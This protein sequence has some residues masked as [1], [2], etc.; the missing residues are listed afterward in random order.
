MHVA[1][2]SRSCVLFGGDDASATWPI[3]SLCAQKIPIWMHIRTFPCTHTLTQ[4]YLN[5]QYIRFILSSN[6]YDNIIAAMHTINVSVSA[7]ACVC[8]LYT[9]IS[10]LQIISPV[11]SCS[12]KRTT[13]CR[14]LWTKPNDWAKWCYHHIL[15][16]FVLKL[17]SWET[18]WLAHTRASERMRPIFFFSCSTSIWFAL[19]EHHSICKNTCILLHSESAPSNDYYPNVFLRFVLFCC[20]ISNN[21]LQLCVV[22][23]SSLFRLI[24]VDLSI[25]SDESLSAW[26][27]RRSIWSLDACWFVEIDQPFGCFDQLQVDW[28]S[29]NEKKNC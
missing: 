5:I 18:V 1:A 13:S 9:H 29:N 10:S 2:L 16:S 23:V 19:W 8:L 27:C 21:L 4:T 6:I 7:S 28:L 12:D 15:Y 22:C 14:Q 20:G 25:S 17:W 3:S 24:I 26:L 11:I